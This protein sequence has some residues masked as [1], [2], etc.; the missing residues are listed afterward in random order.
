MDSLSSQCSADTA[1]DAIEARAVAGVQQV[2]HENQSV[3]GA[4]G[5]HASPAWRPFDG[6]DGGGVAAKFEERLAGL[7]HVENA[8]DVGVGGK[9]GEKMGVVRRCR[10][11]KKRR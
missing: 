11:T 10:E 2:P 1:V 3:V 8:D 4:G 5:E 9:S 7:T 6:V